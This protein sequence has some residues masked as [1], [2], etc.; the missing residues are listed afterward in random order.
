MGAESG[1]TCLVVGPVFGG[2]EM[3]G[4]QGAVGD[5]LGR[6]GFA[7]EQVWGSGGGLR[8]WRPFKKVKNGWV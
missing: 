8:C 4:V 7:I 1:K 6:L 3:S 2:R 5:E